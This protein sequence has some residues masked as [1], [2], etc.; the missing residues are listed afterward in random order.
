[1]SDLATCGCL[2]EAW[3]AYEAELRGWL[4]RRAGDDQLGDDLL[5]DVFV[6]AL[7][8]GNSFCDVRQA[9]AWLFQ[10]ARTTHID[11]LRTQHVQVPLPDLPAAP[12]EEPRPVDS[13]ASCLPRALSELHADDYEVIR[14]C[15]L[16][17]MTQAEF[18]LSVGISLPGAKSRLQRARRRLK[19]HL[20]RVCQVRRDTSGNVCCFVP[21][22]PES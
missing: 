17:G 14:R 21:R 6:K 20:V 12:S 5:A 19:E 18:A 3:H 9:R 13:M 11:H 22:T 2:L 7:R 10:V 4:R 1:M 15:D 16:E 8:M